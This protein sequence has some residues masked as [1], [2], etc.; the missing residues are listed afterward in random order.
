MWVRL[1]QEVFVVSW[2]LHASF[3]KHIWAV[4]A[5][6][7]AI[8]LLEVFV[9]SFKVHSSLVL[10]HPPMLSAQLQQSSSLNAALLK[11]HKFQ[12]SYLFTPQQAR[13]HD[14][15]AIFQLAQN[16]LHLL[17]TSS[18]HLKSLNSPLFAP[19][20]KFTDRTRISVEENAVLD[21]AIEN[22]L[23]AISPFLMEQAA[24]KIIE[25]LVRRYRWAASHTGAEHIL[26]SITEW[27]NSMY[28]HFWRYFYHIILRLISSSFYQYSIYRSF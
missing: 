10:S 24:S 3:H 4:F 28:R 16:G 18:K 1:E 26:T 9:A 6:L 2:R 23:F 7:E 13:L 19:S 8:L 12:E 22:L 17:A 5:F 25:W 21:V 14:L 20:A 11:N 15:D 27:T